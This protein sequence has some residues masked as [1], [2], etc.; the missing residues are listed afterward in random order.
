MVKYKYLAAS[1]P[2]IGCATILE[3]GVLV[4]LSAGTRLA[5]R[6]TRLSRGAA[7]LPW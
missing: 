7:D 1:S 5:D 2:E 4:P 6:K 3:T